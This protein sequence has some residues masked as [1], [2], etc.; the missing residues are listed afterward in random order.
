MNNRCRKFN[1]T[2]AVSTNLRA[3]YFNTASLT[4]DALEANSLVLSAI[5]LPVAGRSENLLAEE[6]FLLWA[7]RAVV[8]GLWLLYFTV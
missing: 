3:R 1:V 6:T 7:Q 8:D 5:T 4:D 2:H